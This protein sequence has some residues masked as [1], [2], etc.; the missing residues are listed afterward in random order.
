MMLFHHSHKQKPLIIAIISIFFILVVAG[1]LNWHFSKVRKLED[2]IKELEKIP[3]DISS[4][5]IPEEHQPVSV[6]G[7]TKSYTNSNYNYTLDYPTNLQIKNY[8]ETNATIGI[9]G[10]SGDEE[11]V[12]GKVSLV[13][14]SSSTATKKTTPIEEFIFN[15]TKLLCD[16]DGGGVSVS[17]PKQNNIQPLQT[18][19]GLPAY[20]L[21]L[22]RE[23]KTFGPEASTVST[24][25]TFFIVDLSNEKNQTILI[26][27]PVG[28]GTTELAKKITESVRQ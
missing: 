17:C 9:I 2:R 1:S 28:D 25:A 5:E 7:E 23:E 6:N 26:V 24:E 21:T 22:T 15:S 8:N 12:N 13:I 14:A 3:L 10:K 18:T 20:T 19:S 4:L 27:Y 16:A 11:F